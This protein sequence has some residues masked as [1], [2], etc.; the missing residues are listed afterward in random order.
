METKNS[1]GRK[2]VSLIA[3]LLALAILSGV[4]YEAMQHSV[5]ERRFSENIYP[6]GREGFVFRKG[7]NNPTGH[8]Y[9]GDGKLDYQIS[10]HACMF[11]YCARIGVKPTHQM[12]NEKFASEYE[13]EFDA[14]NLK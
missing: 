11:P 5:S 1:N 2:S 14:A 10:F 6:L 8:D 4:S 13:E 7:N 3:P 9:D 12:W